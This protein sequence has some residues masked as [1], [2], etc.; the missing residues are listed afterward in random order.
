M[1][2]PV[3]LHRILLGAFVTFPLFLAMLPAEVLLDAGKIPKCTRRVM[4][5]ARG[6]GADID[7]LYDF[8]TCSLLKL[9]WQVVASSV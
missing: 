3:R 2:F 1:S 5:D 6:F 7:P 4:V 9:P 8:S